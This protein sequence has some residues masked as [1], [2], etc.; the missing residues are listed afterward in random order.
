[1]NNPKYI[2]VHC[3]DISYKKSKSQFDSINNAHKSIGFP[4]SSLGIYVGYHALI[5]GEKIRRCRLDTDVGAHCNQ[6]VNGVSMNFQ[7]LGVC[8][9][10]DG[11]VEYPTEVDV[12]L[13]KTQIRT[14]QDLYEIPNDRVYFHRDFR[15]DKTCPGSLITRDWL[16][17]IL[18]R[19]PAPEKT[20]TCAVEEKEIEDLKKE[21]AW[22]EKIFDFLRRLKLLD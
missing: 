17:S 2:V 10:F 21:I 15:K 19:S 8:I 18:E 13:L 4:I 16:N 20:N 5:T 14:W 22:Y 7:S 1:M 9:G 6:S 3:S 12:Q 11:D